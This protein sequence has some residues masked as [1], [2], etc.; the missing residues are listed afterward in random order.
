MTYHHPSAPLHHQLFRTCTV[1]FP[2]FNLFLWMGFRIQKF[3]VFVFL[4]AIFNCPRGLNKFVKLS[5]HPFLPRLPPKPSDNPAPTFISAAC[6]Q[7][8]KRGW[9]TI[10]GW[11]IKKNYLSDRNI[12]SNEF[13]FRWKK[14]KTET[15]CSE[16]RHLTFCFKKKIC[17]QIF[18]FVLL[19]W[20]C[21]GHVCCNFFVSDKNS[22]LATINFYFERAIENVD[23]FVGKWLSWVG[24]ETEAIK[25]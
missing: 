12:V 10:F 9:K 4:I 11:A 20:G 2:S 19:V 5:H 14:G 16:Q 17:L 7:Q 6:K 22:N 8:K 3:L 25:W 15:A 24:F 21:G 13:V 23:R 1:P 18:G